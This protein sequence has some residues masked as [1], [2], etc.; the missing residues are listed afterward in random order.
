MAS[1]YPYATIPFG[2]RYCELQQDAYI[3]QT[4]HKMEA[5]ELRPIEQCG[6]DSCCDSGDFSKLHPA[7]RDLWLHCLS[8]ITPGEVHMENGSEPPT[9]DP[10]PDAWFHH[11]TKRLG[12]FV[13]QGGG[14]PIF[15]HG[16][17]VAEAISLPLFKDVEM[18]YITQLKTPPG[19]DIDYDTVFSM[20]L[21]NIRSTWIQLAR[22]I[23][24]KDQTVF[25]LNNADLDTGKMDD[26][27]NQVFFA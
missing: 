26:N 14:F 8:G 27:G 20:T 6:L 9:A 17:L 25:A 19:Q 13:E 24:A 15:L 11:Y 12:E 5:R 10:T 2:H 7:V 4:I 16:P 22:A 3:F 18:K 21:D 1:G 23:G